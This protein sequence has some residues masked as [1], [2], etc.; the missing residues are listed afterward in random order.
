MPMG[1][2]VDMEMDD[3]AAL[4]AV[5]PIAMASK[6]QYPYGLRICLTHDELAKLG[7][8]AD[9]EVGDYLDIRAFATVTSVHKSDGPGGASCRVEMQI[10][11]MSCENEDH[12]DD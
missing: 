8:E 12:E 9:C 6:S 3:E 1:K 2:L 11:R 10:E 7:L 5:T 4:D